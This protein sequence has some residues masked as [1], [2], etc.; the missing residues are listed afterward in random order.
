MAEM[1]LIETLQTSHWLH[2]RPVNRA[3]P[4]SGASELRIGG[5]EYQGPRALSEWQTR[6]LYNYMKTLSSKAFFV[7]VHSGIWSLMCPW[8]GSFEMS[9]LDSSLV[10]ECEALFNAMQPSFRYSFQTS[11]YL[12]LGSMT[13]EH[14]P[15]IS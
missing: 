8:G 5:A 6:V 14:Q 3:Q 2:R 10:Q 11:W 15:C 9:T 13:T 4:G 12:R 1:R 7:D